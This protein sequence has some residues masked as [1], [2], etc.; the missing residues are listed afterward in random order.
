M[1]WPSRIIF[2]ALDISVL[3]CSIKMWQ[4]NHILMPLPAALTPMWPHI[5]YVCPAGLLWQTL[6][7]APNLRH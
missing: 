4:A 5:A 7:T 2:K 3:P 1:A 6:Q